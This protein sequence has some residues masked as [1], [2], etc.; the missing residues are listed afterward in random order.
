[1]DEVVGIPASCRYCGAHILPEDYFCPNCGKELR[2]KPV[3]M[4]I[5]KQIG[6]YLLSFLLPPLGLWPGIKYLRQPDKKVKTV[7]IV[8]IL[9]TVISIALTFWITAI[10]MNGYSQMLNGLSHGVYQPF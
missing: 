7:G 5:W 9:L 2:V 4:G 6:I 3:S 8:S 10:F 1:M